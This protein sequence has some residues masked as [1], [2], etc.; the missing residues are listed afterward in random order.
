MSSRGESMTAGATCRELVALMS[1]Y[2]SPASVEATLRTVLDKQRLSAAD[3][4]PDELPEVV[5]EAMVGLRLFCDPDRLPD[6]MVDLAEL[7]EESGAAVDD[8]IETD[9]TLS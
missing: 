7:C 2:L 1:A 8:A 9:S 3:L 6:L 4:G 5:A